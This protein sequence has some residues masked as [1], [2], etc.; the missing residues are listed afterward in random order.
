MRNDDDDLRAEL[1]YLKAENERLKKELAQT[2]ADRKEAVDALCKF[3]PPL[4][5]PS[6][7]EM[8]EQMKH[9]VPASQVLRELDEILEKG[10]S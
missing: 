8:I 6:E 5:L 3:M 1:E 2:R 7:E 10:G 9:M 4:D